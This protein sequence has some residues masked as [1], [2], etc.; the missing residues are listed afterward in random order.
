MVLEIVGRDQELAAVRAFVGRTGEDVGALVLEGE[1][2][3]GKSTLW[4]AGVEEARALG[5]RVLSSR[6]AEAERDLA[7]VGLAD[8]FEPVLDDVL[9]S[10]AAPRR[11]RLH[12]L[13]GLQL[14][15]SG[16]DRSDLPVARRR[17]VQA[18]PGAE[19]DDVLGGG[20]AEGDAVRD[21][22]GQRRE[23]GWRRCGRSCSSGRRSSVPSRRRP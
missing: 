7:H 17:R 13:A 6:P 4:L 18:V 20:P 11:R 16:Q 21:A 3:I 15:L 10:L 14:P 2:G 1:A 9:P 23:V 19:R 22:S 8:L 5:E 12:R